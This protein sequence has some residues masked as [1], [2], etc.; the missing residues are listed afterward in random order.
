MVP[1]AGLAQYLGRV[2]EV[3][4]YFRWTIAYARQELEDLLRRRIPECAALATVHDLRVTQRGPSG[5]AAEVAID[6][7]DNDGREISTRLA[8]EYRIR[9]VLH[10]KFL[11]SSAF[12][13][14]ITRDQFGL[15]ETVTLRGAGWGHWR[16][17][18]QS[19][20][21]LLRQLDDGHAAD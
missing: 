21:V 8:R 9:E 14:R 17:S 11:Y 15:P 4:S 5:R 10:E 20:T 6:W 1:E 2:D 7:Q 13:V 16:Q 18:S 19:R 12:A 3:G